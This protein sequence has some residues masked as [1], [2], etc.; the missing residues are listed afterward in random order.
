MIWQV[1]E[2]HAPSDSIRNP[3]H[4]PP[5]IPLKSEEIVKGVL[6][7]VRAGNQRN[8]YGIVALG[9]IAKTLPMLRVVCNRCGR[10]GRYRHAK[11]YLAG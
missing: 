6:A 11:P 2:M 5:D 1:V 9:E 8:G 7:I 4:M 3:E 10:E